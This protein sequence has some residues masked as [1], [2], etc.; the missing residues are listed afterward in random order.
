MLAAGMTETTTGRIV[1]QDLDVETVQAMVNYIYRGEFKPTSDQFLV[2]LTY[3][4]VKYALE[5]LKRLCFEEM[6]KRLSME[7]ATTFAVV[8]SKCG[9]ENEESRAQIVGFCKK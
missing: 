5:D 4:A 9:T 3:C 2:C 1:I 7:N 6:T 8:A